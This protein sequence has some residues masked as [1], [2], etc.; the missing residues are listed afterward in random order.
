MPTK[1]T[2]E[3]ERV[4]LGGG[5]FDHCTFRNCELVFDGNPADMKECRIE[6]CRHSFVGPASV[7]LSYLSVLCASD[8]Q[9][10]AHIA[11]QLGIQPSPPIPPTA[12]PQT[13][14]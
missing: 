3:N 10:A 12:T 2:Y 14:H 5:R 4:V 8:P 13:K 6:N 1:A 9:T 7:T 11:Q